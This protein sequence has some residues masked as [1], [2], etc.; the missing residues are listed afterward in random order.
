MRRRCSFDRARP[1]FL[2]DRFE[3]ETRRAVRMR[4]TAWLLVCR[5]RVHDG[6][7]GDDASVRRRGGESSESVHWSCYHASALRLSDSGITPTGRRIESFSCFERLSHR[8]IPG[9]ARTNDLKHLGFPCQSG[10]QCPCARLPCSPSPAPR[11][12]PAF[13]AREIPVDSA[14]ALSSAKPPRPH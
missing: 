5:M 13:H 3:K 1:A 9:A 10:S 14:G 7:R 2:G 11:S 4:K 8:Q 6:R 12:I